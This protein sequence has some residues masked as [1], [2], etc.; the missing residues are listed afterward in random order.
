MQKKLS[1][2]ATEAANKGRWALAAAAARASSSDTVD[3]HINVLG[4]MHEVGLLKN[5]Q[6]PFAKIW[7]D[8]AS[9]FTA[10][11]MTRLETGDSDYWALAALLGMRI[12]DVAP[13]FIGAGFE[14][15]AVTR[16]PAFKDPEL[17]VATLARRQPGSPEVLT[18]PID[19][20]WDA[21][22]GELFDVSR[23]RAIILEQHTG[24]APQL[25]GS[26]F[27]SYCMRAKLP[28]GCWRLLHDKFSL[29][30]D[31]AVAPEATLWKSVGA[32]A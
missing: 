12:A 16:I 8:D 25:S 3:D 19:L 2:L 31:M 10:A 14:L 7:R 30:A 1:K 21:R 29:D 32:P 26:G 24:V 17:H 23:W 5:S 22:T 6:A 20:G 27:G 18:A 9:A 11:C 13:V 28:F 15:L 4:A